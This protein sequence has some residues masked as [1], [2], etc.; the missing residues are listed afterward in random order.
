MTVDLFKDY[1]WSYRNREGDHETVQTDQ[2][3]QL[4]EGPC[5]RDRTEPGPTEGA[6]GNYPE[7]GSQ[8]GYAGHRKLRADPGDH[9]PAE[10]PGAWQPPDRGRQ[11]S[12][13]CRCH[14]TP[15]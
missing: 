10:N 12:A 14:Q 15:A 1:I 5:S 6:A 11:G 3:D 8:G 4:P 7:R 9:G 13:R 2:T